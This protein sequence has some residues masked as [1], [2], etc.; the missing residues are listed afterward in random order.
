MRIIK[1]T[2]L[3]L[4][5]LPALLVLVDPYIG[6]IAGAFGNSSDSSHQRGYAISAFFGALLFPFVLSAI[7]C[8]FRGTHKN[9]ESI[10]FGACIITWIAAA[11]QLSR[12]KNKV[13][14]S[15]LLAT[16][17]STLQQI[18]NQTLSVAGFFKL[19]SPDETGNWDQ[20]QSPNPAIGLQGYV[21]NTQDEDLNNCTVTVAFWPADVQ[22]KEDFDSATAGMIK[23]IK[24]QL[25]TSGFSLLL[26]SSTPMTTPLPN[27]RRVSFA[28]KA[29][30]GEEGS[31]ESYLSAARQGLA[32][33]ST[34]CSGQAASQVM[35]RILGG[36]APL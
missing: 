6:G 13:A 23:G 22:S 29:E 18:D 4:L 24:K 16:S 14:Q 11:G 5:I 34:A 10:L 15:E 36:L 3:V 20:T 12:P 26:E 1:I 9:F 33:V 30:N 31:S 8:R 21:L 19:R 7:I 28:F 25:E 35:T 27:S 32:T 2:V 17:G